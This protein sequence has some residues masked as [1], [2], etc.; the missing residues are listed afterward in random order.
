MK[1]LA[2]PSYPSYPA[3]CPRPASPSPRHIGP[4]YASFRVIRVIRGLSAQELPH[5]V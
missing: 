1:K 3:Y 5:A 4:R 2:Y